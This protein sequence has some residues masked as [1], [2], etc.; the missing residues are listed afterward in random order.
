MAEFGHYFQLVTTKISRP[1]I[2]NI[3]KSLDPIPDG[4]SYEINLGLLELLH[5]KQF[6]G[7]DEEGIYQH[8]QLFD[9]ICGPFKLHVFHL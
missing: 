3:F 9:Q 4:V 1:P 5:E 7:N 2:R 8:L 6:K